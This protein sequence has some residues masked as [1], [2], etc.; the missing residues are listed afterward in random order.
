M[1][2]SASIFIVVFGILA[3]LLFSSPKDPVGGAQEEE[4]ARIFEQNCTAAGCH[5]GRF[6]PK[7]LHLE[8]DKYRASLLDIPSQELPH[9][10]LIDTEEPEKS[11]LLM[12]IKGNMAISGKRMPLN[13]P[14]LPEEDIHA[15]E[16]WI[17]NLKTD[18]VEESP[19]K[20][21]S[22]Q[23]RKVTKP[24]FWGTRIVNLPTTQTIDKGRVLF[25]ISHRYFPA[26]SDGYDDFYGL[27]GP[28]VILLSLGYGISDKLSISL[29]R[30]NRFKEVEASVKWLVLEQRDNVSIPISAALNIGGA[31]ITDNEEGGKTFRSENLKFNAHLSISRQFSRSFSVLL[32]PAYSSNTNHWET[33]SEGTL[34]LGL[35][36][37]YMFLNDFSLIAEWM[38]ILSGYKAASSGWGFGLEKK[39]GGHVFQVFVTNSIGMTSSQ[40][41][42]GGNLKLQDG[43]FRIGFNIFRLF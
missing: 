2:S 37:R 43:D 34:S 33:P 14:S 42:P 40:F 7:N 19:E 3:V 12:K 22:V 15:L 26:V 30:S 23:S 39:I 29:A 17:R 28:A 5:Q 27:D 6:P 16:N 32:V 9:L 41:L 20:G 36:A 35:G 4:I 21:R 25:R 31:V 13:A 10:R 1:K 24:A 8:K 38:P 18:A 11:Y